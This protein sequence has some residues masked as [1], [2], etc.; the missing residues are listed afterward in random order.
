MIS[1]R[2][3]WGWAKTPFFGKRRRWIGACIWEEVIM[4]AVKLLSVRK[5]LVFA[6]VFFLIWLASLSQVY[7]VPPIKW[8]ITG[9]EGGVVNC[10][11]SPDSTGT[12]VYAGCRGG[13]FKSIDAGEHW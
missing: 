12:V 11:A 1:G 9:P 3:L 8:K 7:A 10:L 6:L 4:V 5:Y 2:N 13:I